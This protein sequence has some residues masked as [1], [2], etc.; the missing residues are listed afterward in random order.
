MAWSLRKRSWSLYFQVSDYSSEE[1]FKDRIQSCQSPNIYLLSS[2][3]RNRS[4]RRCRQSQRCWQYTIPDCRRKT[5]FL[6][7]WLLYQSITPERN[8][9]CNTHE[10]LYDFY[11]VFFVWWEGYHKSWSF[12]SFRIDSYTNLHFMLLMKTNHRLIVTILIL[13]PSVWVTAY[14]C[15]YIQWVEHLENWK[16]MKKKKQNDS[17]ESGRKE[18]AIRFCVLYES[19]DRWKTHQ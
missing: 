19:T 16:G 7:R 14:V 18:I 10:K 2:R 17:S 3:K 4:L 6:A 5:S 9:C 8:N 11:G 1:W 13:S 15:E 12:I